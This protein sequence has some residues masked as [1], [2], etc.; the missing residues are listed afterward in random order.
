[1]E[2]KRIVLVEDEDS[3]LQTLQ[4]LL[5][6]EGFRVIAAV[7]GMEG[8]NKIRAEKPD[9]VILDIMLPK[10]DGYKICGLLKHDGRYAQIPVIML[11]ARAQE[12]D[13]AMGKEV[14]ADAYITKPFDPEALMATIKKLIK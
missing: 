4:L 14:Y 10:L 2:G 8:L 9:I 5:E 3:I 1:M 11:T 7:D 13:K 12:S 6:S